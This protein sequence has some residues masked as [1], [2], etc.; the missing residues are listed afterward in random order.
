[1]SNI[2]QSLCVS[3]QI[4]LDSTIV[5]KIESYGGLVVKYNKRVNLISSGDEGKI[6]SRHLLDSLQPLRHPELIPV[7][8]SRW[9]DMGCG[10]GFPLI[11]LCA[12]LPAIQFYGVEPRQKRSTF[13][14]IV[15]NELKLDNLEIIC[16]NA[17]E[18]GLDNL[19]RVSCRALGSA[20]EDWAR[21]NALLGSNGVFITLKS[22]R[23]CVGLASQPWKT[24][25]YD[26]PGETQTYCLLVRQKGHG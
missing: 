14:K 11:P 5:E 21:A 17:E 8:G 25:P 10:A 22:L 6:A 23:D 15:K 26:L 24:I 13:L 16:N 18:C 1:M 4:S 2:L 12:A 20:E 7:A 9:V 19:D 3:H